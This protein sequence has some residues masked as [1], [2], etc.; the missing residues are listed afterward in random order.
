MLIQ[1][2]VLLGDSRSLGWV[3]ALIEQSNSINSLS[4]NRQ[5]L[6]RL[7]SNSKGLGS[8]FGKAWFK[9]RGNAFQ[10]MERRRLGLSG[11]SCCH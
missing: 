1:E 9:M 11:G 6:L 5:C 8:E 10:G 2:H 3:N 4:E 7:P